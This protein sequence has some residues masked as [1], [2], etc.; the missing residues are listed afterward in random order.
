MNHKIRV[1]ILMGGSSRE[2]EISFAG[3]RTVYDNLNRSLF[4]PVPIFVDS[5][6]NFFLL[7][8]QYLY[9]GTIRDFFPPH[10]LYPNTDFQYYQEQISNA[11][12][13]DFE[14]I[15]KWIPFHE[16]KN[17][18]DFAFLTLHGLK[19][20]DGS[21]QG[22]L[23]WFNIPYSGTG[24]LGS[25]IG[26]DKI[27]QKKFQQSMDYQVLPYILWNTSQ[28]FPTFEVQTR[29]GFP[30]VLK[31]PL[32]GS[33]IG[34]IIVHSINEISKAIQKV[35]LNT[36]LKLKEW[37]TYSKEQKIKLCNSWNDLKNSFH[38][39]LYAEKQ[40]IYNP[41]ELLH[42]LDNFSDDFVEIQA[43]DAPQ[44]ILIEKY[45]EG[46]EFSVIVVHDEEGNPLALPP[47]EI[48]K[49]NNVFDY[50]SKYLP[51]RANKVTPIDLPLEK[52]LKITSQ[53]EKLMM[54]FHFNVYAR[55][56]GFITHDDNIYFNDPNT[57]SGMLPSS[58]FFHQAAEIGF[59][60]SQFLSYIIYI[61]LITRKKEGRF[62]ELDSW[63][64]RL[65][66]GLSHQTQAL[67]SQERIAVI[68]G[69]YSAER[70]I[71]VESGR[72]IAEKL[73]ASGKYQVSPLFLIK[74]DN[75]PYGFELY[76]IPPHLLFKDNADDIAIAIQ[77]Y[78]QNPIQ[79][80]Y[81][82]HI[83]K[84]VQKLQELFHLQKAGIQHYPIEELKNSFDSIFIAIHGRPGEDGQLQRI[85][86][87][88]RI[89]YNG[90]QPIPAEIAMDKYRCNELLHQNGVLVANHFLVKK[91]DF[92]NNPHQLVEQIEKKLGYPMIAKPND[93]G[94]SAAVKKIN[95]HEKLLAYLEVSFTKN[96]NI[97]EK[98]R[99]L[100]QIS[101]ME[102]FP[103]KEE[104]L[105]ETFIED[106]Q[107]YELMEITV[108]FLTHWKDNEIVYE[109]FSPSETI[110][111]SEVLSLEEKFL[112]GQGMN[113]T[114][115]RFSKN[116]EENQRI[117]NI[118]KQ[119]IEKAAKIIGLTGYAR[120]DAFVKMFKNGNIEVWIIEAN[121]LPGMT[122]ATCIFHQ[123]AINGYNPLQFIEKILE[124]GKKSFQVN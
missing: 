22:L 89:S 78:L 94:C 15:G 114:P 62:F 8:W 16:L 88:Q 35:H 102:E 40:K 2:R 64:E 23:E 65:N 12:I 38:F 122:P 25:A 28:P 52:I 36:T 124:F 91:E 86:E 85:L 70:H 87:H 113:I 24:I 116:P 58:F 11:Q 98:Y 67:S 41:D 29:I 45:I 4:E 74:S 76:S 75:S 6:G 53:A 105:L 43:L 57:T 60:P 34:T 77:K 121:T 13:Q 110:R 39:P 123:A 117:E 1:G 73:Q 103:Q 72:N 109:V 21:I 63:I 119:E 37:R 83:Q 42:F 99:D 50:D 69:G 82:E 118:V 7:N 107:E 20:E 3:G 61:S 111:A 104:C 92:E 33:S 19:G 56:D 101:P 59:N 80:P 47:T 18:I 81:T 106:S 9:K 100:L 14:E 97:L 49:K 54:D 27:V 112:A 26:I 108:G 55:I 71:S 120:I 51:G 48:R 95:N 79:H 93:E 32:Q 30:F 68:L 115:A 46:T 96:L 31:N 44:Q 90:S 84:R 66:Q 17:Y 5:Y 10:H